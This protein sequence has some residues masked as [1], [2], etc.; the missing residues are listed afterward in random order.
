M[1]PQ[2]VENA[3]GAARTRSCAHQLQS[4]FSMRCDP[5]K[6]LLSAD[7]S[8]P[9]RGTPGKDQWGHWW[10][11]LR[12]LLQHCLQNPAREAQLLPLL[13]WHQISARFVRG[14]PSRGP[15]QATPMTSPCICMGTS[16]ACLL[17]SIGQAP[18]TSISIAR[19]DSCQSTVQL[20]VAQHVYEIVDET[21]GVQG[22]SAHLTKRVTIYSRQSV[23][24]LTALCKLLIITGMKCMQVMPS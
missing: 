8:R 9:Q 1:L 3:S 17:H 20:E 11:L 24:I 15:V 7:L 6:V 5:T 13:H 19:N 4:A 2:H 23:S 16:Q 22:C 12:L 14:L 18:G 10:G 21:D